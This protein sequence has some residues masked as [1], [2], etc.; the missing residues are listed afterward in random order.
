[1]AHDT[2]SG[3][4]RTVNV[5]SW[6]MTLVTAAILLIISG[7]FFIVIPRFE[8]IYRELGIALP[9]LTE[10]IISVQRSW[11]WTALI[12]IAITNVIKEFRWNGYRN[13]AIWNLIGLIITFILILAMVVGVLIPFVPG[14]FGPISAD[15]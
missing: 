7:G 12:P 3:S 4:P 11:V 1:M 15:A 2:E 13:I 14:S 6:L 10:G 8:M 9:G 5:A